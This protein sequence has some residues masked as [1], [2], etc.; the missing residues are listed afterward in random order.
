MHK[1]KPRPDIEVLLELGVE[2]LGPREELPE[3]GRKEGREGGRE[4]RKEGGTVKRQ[5]RRLPED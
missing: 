2:R 5:L 4:G 1:H 3:L